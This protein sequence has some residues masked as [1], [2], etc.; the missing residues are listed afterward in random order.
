LESTHQMSRL[1]EVG[2]DRTAPPLAPLDRPAWMVWLRRHADPDPDPARAGLDSTAPAHAVGRCLFVLPSDGVTH[3]WCRRG[4]YAVLLYGHLV[5]RAALC[6]RLEI[7]N[8]PA[9]SDAELLLTAY[10]AWGAG[11]ARELEGVYAAA[12][13]DQEEEALLCIRDPIGVMPLFYAQTDAGLVLSS[14]CWTVLRHPAVPRQINR[15]VL[16][17]H[18]LWRHS[19][20]EETF[21]AQVHRI[22]GAH[23]L[24]ARDGDIKTVRYWDPVPPPG[25]PVDWLDPAEQDRFPE[26][27]HRTIASYMALGSAAV[28]LSGGLDSVSVAT[29]ACAV[30]DEYGWP[31]PHAL[32]VHFDDPTWDEREIQTGVAQTL[33]MPLHLISPRGFAGGRSLLDLSL[34][35]SSSY[36]SPLYSLWHPILTHLTE[37]AQSEGHGVIL[38]GV[39]G[40][41]WLGVTPALAADLIRAGDAVG[42]WRLYQAQRKS[43]RTPPAQAAR[44]VLWQYGMRAVMRDAA[45]R[46]M[47]GWAASRRRPVTLPDWIAPDPELRQQLQQRLE[48]QELRP[49]VDSAYV[50]DMRPLLQRPRVMMTMEEFYY[51]SRGRGVTCFHPYWSR[52]ITEFVLRMP[53]RRLNEGGRSKGL[54]RR[55]LAERF[56]QLGFD[57][58]KKLSRNPFFERLMAEQWPGMWRRWAGDSAL[59]DAGVVDMPRLQDSLLKKAAAGNLNYFP[60]WL[61]AE[62]WLRGQR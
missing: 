16:A 4:R 17:E 38:T 45:H 21:F 15:L 35:L 28:A 40:D 27:M 24:L 7:P 23:Y 6:R 20:A 47:P 41:E 19:R 33:G 12:V 43:F 13:W 39:G 50:R 55:M 30:A 22:P 1:S 14:D 44:D 29:V 18:L 5:N 3:A 31:R 36:P 61:L 32:A 53:P 9:L 59:A 49:P 11:V 37:R 2:A 10:E 56:T 46:Y 8:A 54:V 57:R 26:L 58:Q 34:E 42:L 52:P 62:A 48:L 60:V 51:R 25:E